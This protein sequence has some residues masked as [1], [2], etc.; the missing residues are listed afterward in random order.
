MELRVYKIRSANDGMKLTFG[1]RG[2]KWVFPRGSVAAPPS[3]AYPNRSALRRDIIDFIF[4]IELDFKH[5][6]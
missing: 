6:T 1:G 4:C 2:G 5:E 3:A